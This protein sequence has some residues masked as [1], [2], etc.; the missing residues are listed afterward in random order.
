MAERTALFMDLD[1]SQMTEKERKDHNMLVDQMTEIW[2]LMGQMK[3]P[4][5]SDNREVF[6]ELNK[7]I[8]KTSPL[9]KKERNT[10]LKLLAHDVVYNKKDA[11]EFTDHVNAIFDYTTLKNPKA[12]GK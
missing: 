3:S 8:R 1:T 10:M 6:R 9:L 12:K 2:D 5:E 11:R 7:K 4:A